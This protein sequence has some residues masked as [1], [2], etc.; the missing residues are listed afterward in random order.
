M[1]EYI[2]IPNIYKRESY[3]KNRL[4]NGVYA[5]DEIEYISRE[6][7]RW[8]EKVDGT[9]IR[10]IWDGYRVS[11][12]GRTDKA[13]IPKHLLE[14]LQTLFGGTANEEIFEQAFGK[15]EVILY[16]EGYGEKIQ[17]HGNLYGE[18][19][20]ILFD[21][22]VDGLWLYFSSVEDIAKML[23]LKSV[24][25]VGVGTLEEAVKYISS[26]P[27]SR[28]RNYEMEGIVCRPIVP[29]YTRYGEPIRV[30]VKCCDFP[31][32]LEQG[33]DGY[34]SAQPER[35]TGHWIIKETAF[36]DTEAK[37]SNCGFVTLV[38]DPGNGLHMVSDLLFCPRCGSFNGGEEHETSGY[39]QGS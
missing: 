18:V 33:K 19:D 39:I 6:Q 36:E 31:F 11:F 21:I 4:L 34:N 1:N 29:M 12:K 9:N 13:E 27:A 3:G 15:K 38:N 25:C 5:T 17:K 20:F 28:L 22:K 2:K 26:H 16:G 10:V 8:T 30:K 14:R 32:P 23:G 24:P 37:C 35:K 7:W